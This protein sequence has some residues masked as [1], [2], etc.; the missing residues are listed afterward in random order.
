M[1]TNTTTPKRDK[2]VL[3]G[4]EQW[5][6]YYEHLC[7]IKIFGFETA[8]HSLILD[9]MGSDGHKYVKNFIDTGLFG[10]HAQL[11]EQEVNELNNYI[12]NETRDNNK[13]I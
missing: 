2:I 9:V 11:T 5:V 4:F 8:K 13:R 1:E 12:N 6:E 3:G 10:G 7:C